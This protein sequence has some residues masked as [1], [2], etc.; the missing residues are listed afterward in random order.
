MLM[1]SH[2]L[3]LI[4]QRGRRL[5]HQGHARPRQ[6]LHLEVTPVRARLVQEHLSPPVGAGSHR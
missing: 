1:G 4:S 5:R 3:L 6:I 2:S